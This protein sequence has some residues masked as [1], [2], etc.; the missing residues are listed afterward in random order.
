MTRRHLAAVTAL[1]LVAATINELVAYSYYH[2]LLVD[3]YDVTIFD[4]AIRSYSHFHLPVSIV[5]GVHNRFGPDFTVLGDHFSPV[6]ALLAPLYWIHAGP[7]T[8][9]LAQAVLFAL[10]VVPLFA[11]GRRELGTSA[12]YCLCAAYAIAWP[13]AQAAAFPFHEV[14]FAPL[15]VA[16]L[17]ERLSAWRHGIAPVWHVLVAAVAL[18]TVKEDQ[19]FLLAGL[20]LALLGLAV[21][22]RRR[23]MLLLGLGFAVG[24]VAYTAFA[25]HVL[26][27]A[28]GGTANFYWSYD[29]LGTTPQAVAW[30]LISHPVDS[31]HVLLEPTGAKL[32][33]LLWLAALCALAPFASPYLLAALPLLLERFLSATPTWWS[34]EY[35]YNA[36]LVMPL[37]CAGVDGAARLSRRRSAALPLSGV[38]EEAGEVPLGSL[39]GGAVVVVD[40]GVRRGGGTDGKGRVGLVWAVAVL[41]AGVVSVPFFAYG[42]LVAPSSWQ[43]TAANRAALRAAAHVPDGVLVEA[44]DRIGPQITDRTQVLIWDRV[45]FYAPWVVADVDRHIFPFCSLADQ[46]QRVVF[47]EDVGYHVV[48]AEDGYV[49]LHKQ[50]VTPQFVLP[51]YNPCTD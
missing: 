47:L 23:D 15:I 7:T 21:R 39:G 28:F 49:V 40:V 45:P 27:P 31:L 35:Q 51:P 9:F 1:V 41:V 22:H 18:L 29:R 30:H 10:A 26:I 19:G 38:V 37:L 6:L 25:T 14:A 50:D 48:Y 13:L 5:K 4:Q 44:P 46:R 16:I 2:R 42:K 20:G 24:G 43:R 36:Y 34:T 33:T 8:L 11:L 3:D 12:A 32:P 17:F